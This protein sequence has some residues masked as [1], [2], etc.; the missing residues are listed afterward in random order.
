MSGPY[1]L[2]ADS[3]RQTISSLIK[4]RNNILIKHES[5]EKQFPDRSSAHEEIISFVSYLD[6]RIYYYCEQLY[7]L[8]GFSGL[9]GSGCPTNPDG[10]LTASNY[11][12]LPSPKEKAGEQ[13][14]AEL[15]ADFSRSLG[16]FDDML[17]E[18]QN[19][20]ARQQPRNDDVE[21]TSRDRFET[22]GA[23]S[24]RTK[25][26]GDKDSSKSPGKQPG[27]Y[28]GNSSQTADRGP[29]AGR[30]SGGT[31]A[32]STTPSQLPP[33]SGNRDSIQTDD[34][35]IARQLREAAEQETDPEVKE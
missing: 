15:E 28:G 23:A 33:T 25:N 13:R 35:V 24:A 14:L 29:P 7:H 32:G 30:S 10:S 16:R 34:D 11:G 21:T 6:G 4:A 18:E 22:T 2:P 20:V 19:K 12:S 27:A 9:Q 17:L 1:P 8:D 31:G 26:S 5:M 3:L